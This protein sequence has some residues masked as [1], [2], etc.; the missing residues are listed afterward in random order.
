M[1]Q[2]MLKILVERKERVNAGGI[3]A[4]GCSL[5]GANIIFFDGAGKTCNFK[6]YLRF[7]C[8]CANTKRRSFEDKIEGLTVNG[9]RQ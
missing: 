4:R 7:G 5:L 2:N 8:L 6:S 1:P 9:S 3:S